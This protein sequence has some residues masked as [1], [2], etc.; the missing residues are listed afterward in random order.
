M[1]RRLDHS[2]AAGFPS[3]ALWAVIGRRLRAR[4]TQLGMDVDR[5]A[6]ELDIAPAAYADY[7]SGS[8]PMPA[9]LLGQIADLLG[10]PLVWFFQDVTFD[11]QVEDEA[12]A[13]NDPPRIFVVATVEQRVQSLAE[14]FRKL[15]LEGQQ[16]L[17]AIA[18]ALSQ[19]NR[20]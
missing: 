1:V 14:S 8:D 2:F 16:H 10:V 12:A 20:K 7:E 17:L 15:D 5:I 6:E 13:G 4:R 11:A 18:G 9:L 3:R 19:S